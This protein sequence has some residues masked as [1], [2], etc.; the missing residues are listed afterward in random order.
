MTAEGDRCKRAGVSALDPETTGQL[1]AALPRED[2]VRLLRTFQ[3]DLSRLAQELEAAAASGDLDG[4]RRAAHALAGTS[5]GIGARELE[6][7]ARRAMA[8][9]EAGPPP[10][11]VACVT[12]EAR[13]VSAELAALAGGRDRPPA[14]PPA[15]LAP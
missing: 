2:F 4:C 1:A 9:G 3:D 5:A 11:L 13:A 15:A 8:P 10:E 7:A 12:A 6:R 14:P